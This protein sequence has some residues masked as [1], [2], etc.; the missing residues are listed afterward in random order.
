MARPATPPADHPASAC[1]AAQLPP[2]RPLRLRAPAWARWLRAVAAWPPTSQAA[3]WRLQNWLMSDTAADAADTASEAPNCGSFSDSGVFSR[4]NSTSTSPSQNAMRS[5]K[6]IS[7]PRPFLLFR[8]G[9]FATGSGLT[10]VD[11]SQVF[12][13]RLNRRKFEENPSDW[14][15]CKFSIDAGFPQKLKGWPARI[16]HFETISALET[17]R[18]PSALN[19]Q[20]Q[21]MR[22][23]ANLASLAAGQCALA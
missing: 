8:C 21:R 10:A 12:A 7:R 19:E 22:K 23:P 20:S 6:N 9:D 11:K 16:H 3:G 5:R 13:L 17:A 2:R 1:R 14:I 4:G 18:S 15:R